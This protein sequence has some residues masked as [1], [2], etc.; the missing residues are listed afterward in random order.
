M[1][2]YLFLVKP[3]IINSYFNQIKLNKFLNILDK[4]EQKKI[5]D[6]I[7]YSWRRSNHSD[8]KTKLKKMNTIFIEK[9]F[10][11]LISISKIFKYEKFSFFRIM[12]SIE[13][14]ILK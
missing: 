6:W 10:L 4:T 13:R 3:K 12:N 1:C 9:G 8:K 14:R 2:S 5:Q 7:N 11:K